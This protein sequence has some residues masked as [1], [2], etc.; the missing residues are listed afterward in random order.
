MRQSAVDLEFPDT[1]QHLAGRQYVSSLQN[2]PLLWIALCNI[3][4]LTSP[5]FGLQAQMQAAH[6]QA[7]AADVLKTR[8]AELEAQLAA[9]SAGSA[10]GGGGG[11][12][13][14]QQQLHAQMSALA[15]AAEAGA[16]EADAVG[17][18]R[19]QTMQVRYSIAV[20]LFAVYRQGP[21]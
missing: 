8:I 1:A 2:M 5:L 16:E 11:A 14:G 4:I 13:A 19:L 18:G 15:E 9:A 10:A 7:H 17:A 20:T 21:M 12:T 3:V 6:Q